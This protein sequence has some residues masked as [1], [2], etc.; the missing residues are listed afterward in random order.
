MTEPELTLEE[1]IS[2][3]SQFLAPFFEHR[4]EGGAVVDAIDEEL[5][6]VCRVHCRP[7]PTDRIGWR[8]V[9]C[10]AQAIVAIAMEERELKG[11]APVRF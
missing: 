10:S 2:A 6:G 9:D 4:G 5:P 7:V 3:A 11:E 1:K 8:W